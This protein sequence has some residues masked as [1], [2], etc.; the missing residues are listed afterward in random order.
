MGGG[1]CT[2][3]DYLLLCTQLGEY[4]LQSS[5]CLLQERLGLSRSI[6]AIA[7]DHGCSG[8]V[9]GLSLAKGLIVGGMAS[10]VL[11]VTAEI[12]TKYIACTDKSTRSIFGDGA[13]ATLVNA[14]DV[15][16]IFCW[17]TPCERSM[18]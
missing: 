8:F 5:A 7:F 17:D 18:A 2:D 9:Y 4:R 16:N 3:V 6:G 14:T 10:N 11:L 1:V 15:K 13:A 12:Y